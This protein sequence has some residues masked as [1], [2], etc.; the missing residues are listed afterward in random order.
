MVPDGWTFVPS[1][2][3]TPS[4]KIDR[5]ALPDAPPR[6]KRPPDAGIVALFDRAV[7]RHADAAAY[8]C[9]DTA[10]TFAEL[11]R[12]SRALAKRLVECGVGRDDV[13]VLALPRDVGYAVALIA[14]LRAGGACMPLDPA[15]P[16]ERNAAALRQ[17]SARVLLAATALDLG[18]ELDIRR[19]D[20][21]AVGETAASAATRSTTEDTFD[22]DRLAFVLH[23]SG[24]TGTPKAVEISEGQV[25]HRLAWDWHARPWTPGEVACQRGMTGFVDTIAEWLGPLLR[26]VTTVIIADALLLNPREMIKTLAAERVSRILLVPS[27]LDLLL[28]VAPD[29]A[30]GLPALHL[31]TASGEPLTAQTVRRFQRAI[32]GGE[33]WNV[34]GATE[35]WDATCMRIETADETAGA[36]VPIGLP[37][38]G[39]RAY[40]V[41]DALAPAP[42]GTTGDLYVAGDG[43]A[44]GYRV[45]E[46]LTRE[47]F[48]PNPFSPGSGD[49]LYRTGDRARMREDGMLECLGRSDRLV[50]INGVRIELGEIEAVF[51]LH[52]DVREVAVTYV[53][54]RIV[55]FIVGHADA[56]IDGASLRKFASARLPAVAMPHEVIALPA[57]PRNARGKIDRARLLAPVRDLEPPRN[58]IERVLLQVFAEV[59]GSSAI[60][61]TTDFFD[62][63][64]D[65]LLAI[66]LVAQIEA[67]TGKPFRLDAMAGAPTPRGIAE[68]LN[69]E[70][71]AWSTSRM[72]INAGGTALP[73]FGICGAWGSALRLLRIGHALGAQIPFHA[74]QPPNMRWPASTPM[75]AMAAHYADEIV[76]VSP[77]GP[78]RIIGTSFGGIMAF[79][80]ALHLQRH[81][82]DVALLCAVDSAAPGTPLKQPPALRA[83]AS[84]IERDGM[85]VFIA[86][87]EATQHY[88][89]DG[90]YRGRAVY[91][92]CANTRGAVVRQWQ[93]L[94]HDPLQIVPIPGMHGGFHRQPQLGAIA[95]HL[96]EILSAVAAP[97]AASPPVAQW[98]FAYTNPSQRA[99][100]P[101]PGAVATPASE[102]DE[103]RVGR[104]P[105]AE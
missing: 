59:L 4:G 60:G 51:A 54:R 37:L 85:D 27:Q 53:D 62:Q 73:L 36:A 80:V 1:L 39:M 32:P 9:G 102:A 66:K 7:A 77:D 90:R 58:E 33:L 52:E 18:T 97:A 104:D 83:D 48:I 16:R 6:R 78:Y 65:S 17:S 84:R 74:L 96:R 34:Y 72:T 15:G 98:S 79:E 40:V 21:A 3:L 76:S 92:R 88:V 81:G 49:R 99:A 30:R 61:A 47:R 71:P 105:D 50:K 42:V 55:A 2:P 11:D 70:W 10:L 45:D 14:V 89:P 67:A 12:R 44:R 63:G 94:L 20:P 95:S 5:R 103:Q 41:D 93:R 75:R 64:G 28:D 31:W 22:P 29:L 56:R 25:L 26:G 43:L 24:S 87:L 68:N 13:V 101:A 100:S 38:P 46:A 35:A 86:H 8:R 19:I 91:F 57:M 82:H 69:R 23:T